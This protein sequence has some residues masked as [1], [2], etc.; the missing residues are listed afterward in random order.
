MRETVGG[1]MGVKASGG[2]RTLEDLQKMVKSGATRIG[3][4]AGVRIMEQVLGGST[5][6]LPTKKPGASY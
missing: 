4:S 6:E 1:E 5:S 2:V 3:C